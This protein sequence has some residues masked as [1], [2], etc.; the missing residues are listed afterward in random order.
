AALRTA[1]LMLGVYTIVKA[2]EQSTSR[3]L[4]LGA[5]AVALIIAFVV[6]QART[7]NPLM[8]L[9][10]FR[11]RNVTGANLVQGLLVVGMFGTFFL[12]ALYFQEVRG[13]GPLQ[14]GLA[15]LPSTVAM[16]VMSLRVAGDVTRRFGAHPTLA[17]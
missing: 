7:A 12:G 10:L 3:T 5:T 1:G 4:L 13:Y 15:F 8:P 14:I 17:V 16:G 6:R 9:R 2:A 11:S